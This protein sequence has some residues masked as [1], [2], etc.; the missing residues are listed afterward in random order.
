MEIISFSIHMLPN[1]AWYDV[2]EF[3]LMYS[4]SV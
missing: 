1:V 4:G 2:F 3:F